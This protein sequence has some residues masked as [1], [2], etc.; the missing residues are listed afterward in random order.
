M[1]ASQA[2]DLAGMEL[3]KSET[4]CGWLLS[5][6]VDTASLKMHGGKWGLL[7]AGTARQPTI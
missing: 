6:S 3:L 7:C 1:G 2:K 5:S 4:S